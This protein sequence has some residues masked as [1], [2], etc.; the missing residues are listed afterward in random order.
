MSTRL[1]V[2]SVGTGNG[3][4]EPR[5]RGGAW[6]RGI[7]WPRRL[8]PH[9]SELALP[10]SPPAR[11][12]SVMKDA[13]PLRMLWSTGHDR[14]GLGSLLFPNH[15]SKSSWLCPN[16][17]FSRDP[18]KDSKNDLYWERLDFAWLPENLQKLWED[19]IEMGLGK[20]AEGQWVSRRMRGEGNIG[21]LVAVRCSPFQ[22]SSFLT[23]VKDQYHYPHFTDEETEAQRSQWTCPGL[24]SCQWQSFAS[25]TVWGQSI[26]SFCCPGRR[27][28]RGPGLTA[29]LVPYIVPRGDTPTYGV[30]LG[31][32]PH[33]LKEWSSA[34]ARVTLRCWT[35]R[36]Q[37]KPRIPMT[38]PRRILIIMVKRSV[39]MKTESPKEIM[40]KWWLR[41]WTWCRYTACELSKDPW[42]RANGSWCPSEASQG[43]EMPIQGGGGGWEGK[44]GFL[45]S[46]EAW[47][48]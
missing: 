7:C 34:K 32:S 8:A 24:H 29:I 35:L 38:F 2:S 5:R 19:L 17:T 14:T 28:G 42:S 20:V 22:L 6:E 46:W 40:W 48:V 1:A 30:G 43:C 15:P 31:L 44:G 16:W 36:P 33:V 25:R 11:P 47:E 41:K 21:D 9:S 37:G 23:T 10:P 26:S 39:Q 18:G 3:N 27:V 4:L 45:L 13:P 12:A